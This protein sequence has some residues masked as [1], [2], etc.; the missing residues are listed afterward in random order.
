MLLTLLLACVQA[1]DPDGACTPRDFYLD[2][3]H[4]GFGGTAETVSDCTAPTGFAE[5]ADDC[6]DQVATTYPGADES[7]N[8]ADDDCN[9]VLDDEALDGTTFYADGDGDG[10]GDVATASVA[11]AAP[12]GFVASGDDCDD[13]DINV[14]PGAAETCDGADQDCDGTTD[15]DPIDAPDLYADAD[16]DGY[17]DAAAPVV[18]CDT[19]EGIVA[20]ASDCDDA[21]PDVHPGADEHCDG[22]D[23]DC[24][25]V[26][27]NAAVDKATWY[28]DA[29]GDGV[30]RADKSSL[31]CE[32]PPDYVLDGSDC[33]DTD[34]LITD[35]YDFWPDL[36][37]DAYGAGTP[38]RAC[39]QP[40]GLVANQLDCDDSDPNAN[41]AQDEA[42]GGGDENCDGS[43]DE[44]D[45]EG[46]L[47]TFADVDA[48]GYGDA[49][50]RRMTCV[51]A[52]GYVLDSTDCDDTDVAVSPAGIEACN[53]TDDNCDGVADEGFDADADGFTTCAGD[54]D[55]ADA[56][57]NPDGVDVCDDGVD[58]DCSG[59]EETGCYPTGSYTTADATATILGTSASIALGSTS[60]AIGDLDKDGVDEMLVGASYDSPNGHYSGSAWVL[61]GPLDSSSTLADYTLKMYGYSADDRLGYAVGIVG[62]QDADGFDD[63]LV[64]APAFIAS[65]GQEGA[66][67]VVSGGA[68]GSF[69]IP[70]PEDAA[71][72][73]ILGTSVV[74]IGNH[75]LAGDLMGTGDD[76]IV[77]GEYSAHTLDVVEGPVTS[78]KKIATDAA[79]GVVDSGGYIGG[80]ADVGDFNGDGA[81]DLL[82][83]SYF[84]DETFICYGPLAGG[85]GQ[86][87]AV[88]CDGYLYDGSATYIALGHRLAA[89]G[90]VDAD[91]YEDVGVGASLWASSAE[92]T[93]RAGRWYIFEGG[94][95]TI[96]GPTALAW[97]TLSGTSNSG[98]GQSPLTRVGDQD[99]DGAEDLAFSDHN[100]Q[101][102]YLMVGLTSGEN[103]PAGADL[104]ITGSSTGFLGWGIGA[105]GD[106][107]GDGADDLVVTDYSSDSAYTDAGAVYLFAL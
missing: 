20:T 49:A 94:S 74:S 1:V 81:D 105:G 82:A 65:T 88:A 59:T 26:P 103:D 64:T 25:D 61:D 6:D 87:P 83:A 32:Q 69:W 41:P 24:D 37:V 68:S 43:V 77:V 11:C 17:G 92:P 56:D 85:T 101:T 71:G 18:A 102:V 100:A 2:Y 70:N 33:D 4:D 66:V 99:L 8:G 80:S 27:D 40:A 42:C 22:L 16:L 90:D 19:A 93:V 36:D 97:A 48:D 58:Q 47:S 72:A 52:A 5:T 60:V 15:N 63:W 13:A 14:H 106:L 96:Y 107:N 53:D 75:A 62:D 10:Y 51:L 9:G 12:E 91:G 23:E 7:C 35:G 86:D 54:C 38:T 76:D 104:I 67:C 50:E 89:L 95:A 31:D 39:T 84:N 46:A 44:D 30:G 3:D 55:D 78:R 45:A 29:D 73:C 28:F 34:E 98:F 21:D 79:W 57:T